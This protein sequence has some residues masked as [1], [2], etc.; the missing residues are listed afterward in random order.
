MKTIIQYALSFIFTISFSADITAQ[1]NLDLMEYKAYLTNSEPLWKQ[2]VERRMD[3]YQQSH[4]GEDLYALSQAQYGLLLLT[5]VD[6]DE[7]LFD[8]YVGSTVDNLEKLIYDK[9]RMGESKALLSS[10][11]GLKIAYSNWKG[12]T[13]GPKSGS[14]I[15]EAKKVAPDSPLVWKLY[16]NFK[17]YTPSMFGGDVQEAIDAYAKSVELFERNPAN[18]KNNWEY[19][20][21]VAW[22]GQAYVKADEPQ[23][24]IAVYQKAL[25]IEPK[26][27]WVKDSLLPSAKES[28]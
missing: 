5:M 26:F 15:A 17:L 11:Y 10:V 4:S 22:L 3:N 25:R 8:E 24:A 6:M 19:L 1:D 12:M 23:K 16:G 28:E 21:A 14:L 9:V 7:D 27:N 13:L 18:T 20:D 2:V